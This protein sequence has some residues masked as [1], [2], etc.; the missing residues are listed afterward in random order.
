MRPKRCK[1]SSFSDCQHFFF[2]MNEAP[3]DFQEGP[4]R[5]L[6][7]AGSAPA[8]SQGALGKAD[9]VHWGPFWE[10]LDEQK[11]VRA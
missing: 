10:A 3:V 8:C 6:E 9:Q 1:Y 4:R 5:G 2:F 11:V 7:Q